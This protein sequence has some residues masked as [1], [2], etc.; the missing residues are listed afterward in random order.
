MYPMKNC[1]TRY[2]TSINCQQK[3]LADFNLA[4]EGDFTNDALY[5]LSEPD[6]FSETEQIYKKALI[7]SD[8]TETKDDAKLVRVPKRCP[9]QLFLYECDFAYG[10]FYKGEHLDERVPDMSERNYVS[11]KILLNK[12]LTFFLGKRKI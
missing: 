11:T 4:A 1:S 7:R 12:N 6:E 3:A 10:A 8:R 9:F 5:S 2:C